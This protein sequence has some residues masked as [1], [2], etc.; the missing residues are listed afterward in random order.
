VVVVIR[1]FFAGQG[2]LHGQAA[3]R[4]ALAVLGRPLALCWGLAAFW[5]GAVGGM[6]PL[7]RMGPTRAVGAEAVRSAFG[8]VGC[9]KKMIAQGFR[10]REKVGL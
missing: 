6:V 5:L 8:S 9:G 3:F 4:G 7:R 2:D 10:G 1:W